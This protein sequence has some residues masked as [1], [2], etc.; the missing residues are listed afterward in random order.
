M[1][2]TAVNETQPPDRQDPTVGQADVLL[3]PEDYSQY[4]LHSENEILFILR[5]LLA[6]A[7]RITVYFNQGKDFLLTAV[8]AVAEDGLVLDHSSN[9]DTNRRAERRVGKEG[10][11]RWAQN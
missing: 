8:V 2:P 6:R 10:R 3:K 7:A 1:E 4:L 9:M 11:S 5:S